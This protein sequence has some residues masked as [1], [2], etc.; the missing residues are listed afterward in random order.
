MVP[1]VS[2]VQDDLLLS[3]QIDAG[4][5]RG[6]LIRLGPAVDEILTG[7]GYPQPVGEMLGET[8]AL[9]AALAGALKYDGVFTL[10]TQS[11]GPIS[12][13]V[14]DVTSNGNLRGYARFDQ[15]KLDAALAPGATEQGRVPRLLGKGHIAFT[16][17]QGADTDRYQGIVE[18]TGESLADCANEYF[19]QSEQ[20]DTAFALAAR[21]PEAGNGWRA[22]AIMIQ[23]MPAGS[24]NLPILTADEADEAWNRA[25]ILLG[26]ATAGEMLNKDLAGEALLY[27]LY[28][29]DGLIVQ[30]SRDLRAQCRCSAERVA[31]TLRSFPREQVEEMKAANGAVEVVC[32]FCKTKYAFDTAALDEIYGP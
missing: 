29:A 1:D 10:Q 8:I 30:A 18:L 25:R 15:D 16:V 9:A 28:H 3:F 14:A 7:H 19:R 13:L 21:A 26:S 32:E 2:S 24:A 17:D 22:G 11:D 6:R 4:A 27:R 31:G 5:F 23:R 12:M 20:L